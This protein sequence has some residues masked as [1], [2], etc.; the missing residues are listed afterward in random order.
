MVNCRLR[1][2]KHLLLKL[3]FSITNNYIVCAVHVAVIGPIYNMCIS[4]AVNFRFQ[5]N[6]FDTMKDSLLM[7][8][9]KTL[10]LFQGLNVHNCSPGL[11]AVIVSE[12][13]ILVN[14]L[15]RSTFSGNLVKIKPNLHCTLNTCTM[16]NCRLRLT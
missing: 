9:K 4:E 6:Y 14:K 3:I 10:L 2:T 11:Q 15:Q 13:S 8:F 1:L 12:T 16:L 7:H 5:W